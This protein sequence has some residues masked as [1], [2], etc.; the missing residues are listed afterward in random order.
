[1]TETAGGKTIVPEYHALV[2]SDVLDLVPSGRTSVLDVGGG[3][4]AS[5]AHL[6]AERKV[7]RAVVVDLVGDGALPEID[8]A[9][10][11]NLE[12]PALLRQIA[13]EQ[14]PFDVILC[15]DVLEHLVDPWSVV[16]QLRDMLTPDGVIVASIPNV[17]NY[18]LVWPLVMRGEFTLADRGILDRTHLRWFVRDTA[19]DLMTPDG[20][21]L[22]RIDGIVRGRKKN[23][24][25]RLTFRRFREFLVIQ[26]YIRVRKV[27]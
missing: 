21:K 23:L 27:A 18:N 13:V 14:G 22:E 16:R 3:I 9:Y 17:R 7:S 20:L 15:L 11:G 10:G 2:R 8:A 25:D 4:G 24:F 19:I 12:D 5:A 1:M 26:Y 6:K